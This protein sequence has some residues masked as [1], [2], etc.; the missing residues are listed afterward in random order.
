MGEAA[1]RDRERSVKLVAPPPKC[2]DA[3]LTWSW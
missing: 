3:R 1:S 2:K